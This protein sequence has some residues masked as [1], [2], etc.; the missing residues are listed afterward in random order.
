MAFEFMTKCICDRC[1]TELDVSGNSDGIPPPG[2]ATM[3]L[4]RVGE[5]WAQVI[6]LPPTKLLCGVC[7]AGLEAWVAM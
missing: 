1:G 7:L 5:E 4:R 3:T 2:W 6:K